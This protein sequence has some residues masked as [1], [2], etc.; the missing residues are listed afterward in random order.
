[1]SSRRHRRRVNGQITAENLRG[2]SAALEDER[3]RMLNELAGLMDIN[4]QKGQNGSIM[5]RTPSGQTL[6]DGS[7]PTKLSFDRRPAL[8][9]G[10]SYDA[11]NSGVGVISAETGS[12]ARFDLIAGRRLPFRRDRRSAGNAR[13]DPP[14]GAAAAR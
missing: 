13:R 9:A 1:M 12:G 4:V 14:P 6:F 10:M 8:D 7:S 5:V 2:G 11:A 3:D